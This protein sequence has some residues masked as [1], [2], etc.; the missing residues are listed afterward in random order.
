M[1]GFFLFLYFFGGGIAE[2]EVKERAIKL[3]KEK[4]SEALIYHVGLRDDKAAAEGDVCG[5]I[6]DVLL[7]LIEDE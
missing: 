1:W 6:L 3:L 4:D 5:G 7:E 2:A